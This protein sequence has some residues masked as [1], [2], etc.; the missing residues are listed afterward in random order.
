MPLNYDV[1]L[2]L[3]IRHGTQSALAGANGITGFGLTEVIA[4]GSLGRSR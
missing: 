3:I 2:M 1:S 4:P